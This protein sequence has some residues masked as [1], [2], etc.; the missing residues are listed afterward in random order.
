MYENP[1]V[2]NAA[3][4]YPRYRLESA[5]NEKRLHSFSDAKVL[6]TQSGRASRAVL[7]PEICDSSRRR[8]ITAIS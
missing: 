8:A 2:R 3:R 7:G 6:A 4:N 1:S 5:A